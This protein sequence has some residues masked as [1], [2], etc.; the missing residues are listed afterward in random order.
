MENREWRIF[1]ILHP[2]HAT[3]YS[4]QTTF[5]CKNSIACLN[6]VNRDSEGMSYMIRLRLDISKNKD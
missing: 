3:L 2:F 1:I 6:S 5:Y 4:N